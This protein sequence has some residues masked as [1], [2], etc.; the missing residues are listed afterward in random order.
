MLVAEES[1]IRSLKIYGKHIVYSD[2][3][4]EVLGI[5]KHA[6]LWD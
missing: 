1:L 5:R 4:M 3:R 2:R 6:F